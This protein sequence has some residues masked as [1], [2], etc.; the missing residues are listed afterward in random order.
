MDILLCVQ[1]L[2][3]FDIVSFIYSSINYSYCILMVDFEKIGKIT[4]N[5]EAEL[6]TNGINRYL[7]NKTE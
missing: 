3:E 6:I 7:F 1:A 4:N 2:I 5:E